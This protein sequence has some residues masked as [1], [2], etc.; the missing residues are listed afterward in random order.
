MSTRTL[1]AHRPEVPLKSRRC[2]YLLMVNRAAVG[3]IEAKREGTKLSTVADQSAFY[4][5][6]LPPFLG[7]KAEMRFLYETTGAETFFRDMRDPEPRSRQVFAFHKPDTL[8]EW[9]QRPGSFSD[10]E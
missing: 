3:I 7:V 6:N 9:A 10:L 4:A 8:A 5:G 2:D 1:H